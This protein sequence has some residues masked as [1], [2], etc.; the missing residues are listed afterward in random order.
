MKTFAYFCFGITLAIACFSVASA[1]FQV[2][3][4]PG[5]AV[6]K[7]VT[8]NGAGDIDAAANG[9]GFEE[10][11]NLGGGVKFIVS[12]HAIQKIVAGASA[13]VRLDALTVTSTGTVAVPVQTIEFE[14]GAF[15][16][17]GP[18][19]T[20]NVHLDG[21]YAHFKG[22]NIVNARIALDGFLLPGPVLAGTVAPAAAVGAVPPVKFGPP[23][24]PDVGFTA[25][26][27]VT[28][29]R[30][31]LT[32][33]LGVDDRIRLPGSAVVAGYTADRILTVNSTADLEDG[34]PGDGVCDTGSASMGFTGICTMRAALTEA[35]QASVL[36]AIHF[37]IPASG[38]PKIQMQAD[39]TFNRGSMGALQRVI[40]NGST[41][42]GG[43]VELDGS[44]ASPVDIAGNEVVALDLVGANS[45]V[46]GLVIN[47]FPSHAI[48]IRPTG[49]P[50]GGSNVIEANFIGTD[51][52][53]LV[54]VP[55]GGDGVHISQM[56]ANSVL[57][58][59][60]ANN[61]GD[62]VSVDGPAAIGNRIHGNSILTNGG[63]GIA[64]SNGANNLQ[65]APAL[66][67]ATSDGDSVSVQG[68]LQ[69]APTRTFT[70][71]F[72]T[73]SQCDPSGSG[74]G[75]T[76]LG[77]TAVTT[78][79]SGEATFTASFPTN[80]A[81]GQI[82]TATATDPDGN[83]SEFSQCVQIS[84]GT[85]AGQFEALISQIE[86]LSTLN[87]GQKNS[88]IS[89]LEAAQRSLAGGNGNAARG[90]LNAFINEVQA[91]ERSRRLDAATA[92]SLITQVQ[93]II[94][95]I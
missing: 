89:K 2:R 42:P 34:L 71:D 69:G 55:N 58:N 62:G 26:F 67:S 20:A 61:R 37:N 3:I 31:K 50:F 81:A 25:N 46:R 5:T 78:N 77:S 15:A 36:T 16:A 70:L 33:S 23:A 94:N 85:P 21:Q 41:Q 7:T 66:T 87:T 53:G 95:G 82:A 4:A 40:I 44:Q 38:L 68:I 59:M 43:L 32:F 80:I 19:F 47:G 30:G 13:E 57:A 56:P 75:E 63:L 24:D 11:L 1:Q 90:Q 9:I 49:A 76:F 52:T 22:G 54:A 60:I 65:S 6:A 12:G 83:T 35:D 73:N 74:E 93:G 8:D 88:L 28:Q 29:L 17:I 18:P 51:T 72:F 84:A 64:L 10:E 92:D 39:T 48:Q 91:I 27:G 14:N 45:T 79:G 86:S